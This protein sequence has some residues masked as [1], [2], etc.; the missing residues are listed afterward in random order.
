MSVNFLNKLNALDK[1]IKVNFKKSRDNVKDDLKGM[2]YDET[3]TK[4]PIETIESLDGFGLMREFKSERQP[5]VVGSLISVIKSKKWER[6]IDVKR[7]EIEDDDTGKVPALTNTVGIASKRTPI[8][9]VAQA[10]LKGFTTNLSDGTPFFD[11]SRGN[12]QTGALTAENL[13][14]ART[15]IAVQ[16]DSEN[17]PLGF[18]ATTLVV[19]PRNAAAAEALINAQQIDGTSNTL[20]HS[21][22]LVVSPFI[23]DL[24]WYVVD[25][26]QGVYPITLVMRVRPDQ[27]VSKTDLN[28]D[29]AFDKDI[30]SW[31]TRGRFAAAYHNPKLIVGSIGE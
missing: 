1:N 20:Y 25:N 18:M 15:K 26:T 2:V 14:A 21:L 27:I 7:E 30:F 4:L 24:S 23:T 28:S 10:L 19:G 12:L 11:A 8:Y 3:P 5:G 6:T 17:A 29:R 31:G 22:K 9:E 13:N 16:K